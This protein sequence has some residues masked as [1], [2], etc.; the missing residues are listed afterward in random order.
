MGTTP[1]WAPVA[2]SPTELLT[3]AELQMQVLDI[4]HHVTVPVDAPA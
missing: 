4:P 1:E 2:D 3:V